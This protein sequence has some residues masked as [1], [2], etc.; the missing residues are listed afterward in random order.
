MSQS[1]GAPGGFNVNKDQINERLQLL[2]STFKYKNPS[3]AEM[4]SNQEEIKSFDN[5]HD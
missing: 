4:Q 5:I 2:K 1:S 3:E